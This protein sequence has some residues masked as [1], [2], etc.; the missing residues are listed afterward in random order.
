[1]SIVVTGATGQLGRLIVAHLLNRGVAPAEITAVGRN[2]VRLAELAASGVGTAVIDYTDPASLEAAFAGADALMLVSGSE[3]G[4]RVA[5]HTNAITAA[6]AAG[7]GR[8]VYTSAPK[9]DTSALILAP[10]HKATEEALHASGLPV[11]I[12]RNGWYTENYA[13]AVQQARENGVYLTS[14]GEGRVA[15]ASRTD[16][17]EAAAVVLT[18]PGHE[19]V[20]YELAGDVA[21]TGTDMAAALTE[22]VGS[23]VVFSSVTPEEHSAILTGAGLDGGT[24][25]F[26]VALDANTRDGLLAGGTNDLATLI[27]RPTTPLIDGLRS[28]A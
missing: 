25:G 17:A 26:V 5:Q 10:E 8:I 14:A 12:L 7:V 18:T 4:Q 11:T 13:S 22:V 19:N 16:Y 24:V 2:T 15:S 23:P 1:M 20:T 27:G 28:V 3:V 9:A 21:W 6:V